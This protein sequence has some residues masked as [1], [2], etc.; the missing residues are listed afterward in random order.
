MLVD[1]LKV[2]ARL[3]HIDLDEASL[4]AALPAFEQ[5][6]DYF[7]AMMAADEDGALREPTVST[8]VVGYCMGPQ[9]LRSDVVNNQISE[10]NTAHN[11]PSNNNPNS[12]ANS[13][14]N[15]PNS[16]NPATNFTLQNSLLN[17]APDVNGRFIVV[18]NVL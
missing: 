4:G 3:A 1:D 8:S 6:L 11:N 12:K 5:M 7:A 14:L 13:N 15:N 10:N 2:T 17:S 9:A 16:N 18:P